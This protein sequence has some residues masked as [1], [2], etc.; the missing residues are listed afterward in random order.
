MCLSFSFSL[1]SCRLSSAQPW[2][3]ANRISN[4]FYLSLSCQIR[5]YFIFWPLYLFVMKAG[6]F[7]KPILLAL[8][9][10]SH[11]CMVGVYN[12]SGPP[13]AKTS[14][15][16]SQRRGPSNNLLLTT[17][18]IIVFKKSFL[19]QYTMIKHI[20]Y[21]VLNIDYEVPSKTLHRGPK[22]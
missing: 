4:C 13:K 5:S 22:V 6:A 2:P 17:V 11:C 12:S 14:G 16:N 19:L 1:S 10:N 15:R 21:F 8:K 18:M 20:I 9:V 7:C 3:A